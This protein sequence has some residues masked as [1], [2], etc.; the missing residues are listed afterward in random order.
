MGTQTQLAV[1][2]LLPSI[3][4]N[5]T[6]TPDSIAFG[7]K[8]TMGTTSQPKRVTIMNAN[9]KQTRLAVDIEMESASP[10]VFAVKSECK[11]TLKPGKSCKVSVTFKPTNTTAQIGSLKIYDNASGSPQSVA[12]SGTGMAAKTK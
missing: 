6:I 1:F 2:G 10:A 7:D 12:L 8:V 3:R 4:A 5:L 11:K 9:S